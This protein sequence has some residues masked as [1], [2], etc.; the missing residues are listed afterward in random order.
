MEGGPIIQ[1]GLEPTGTMA[2]SHIQQCSIHLP[3]GVMA[4]RTE[5][6]AS[7]SQMAHLLAYL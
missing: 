3:L 4:P 6:Q 5:P 7:A 2:F 1:P